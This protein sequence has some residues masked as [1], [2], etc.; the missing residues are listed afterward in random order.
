MLNQNARQTISLLGIGS[1]AEFPIA[2]VNTIKATCSNLS[3]THGMT[4][5]THVNRENG[6]IEVTRKK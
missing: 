6:T 4:F 1:C 3:L 2:R 5:S